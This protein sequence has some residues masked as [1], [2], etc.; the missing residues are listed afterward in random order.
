MRTTITITLLLL[1]GPAFTA[2]VFD[3]G[4]FAATIERKLKAARYM[5]QEC[6][7]V[8]VPGWEGFETQKCTYRVKDRPAGTSKAATVVMLN[9][10]ALKLSEWIMNACKNVLPDRDRQAC[11]QR[12]F[13]HVLSQSGGQFPVAGVVYEDILPA[14]GINEAY[15]FRD[16]VTGII[17]G[18]P[19]RA[20]QPLTQ[21]QTERALSAPVSRTASRSAYARP[22]GV[23]R[24][25]Y[26][27]AHPGAVV[28]NLD[29][30][31]TVRTEYQRA[32]R[33]DRNALIEA[34][35]KANAP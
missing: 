26:L 32:W 29:W 33:S 25:E 11:A 2:D 3:A 1:S 27:N 8:S 7:P 21:E 6:Q 24:N 23:A 31:T 34:W 15:G 19:H 22:I 35:L 13:G 28:A 14:D 20:T 10:S 12:V 18:F 16:G 5:E 17:G 4:S 30:L 9:P